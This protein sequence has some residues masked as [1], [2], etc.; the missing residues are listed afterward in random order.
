MECLDLHGVD[1]FIKRRNCQAGDCPYAAPS[2]RN[3]PLDEGTDIR[4]TQELLG[5]ANLET[6]MIYTHIARELMPHAES[7]LDRLLA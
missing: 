6:T 2:V 1:D 7:P 3:P 5:H 4:E